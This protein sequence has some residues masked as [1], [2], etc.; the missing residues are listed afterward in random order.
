MLDGML[1]GNG[2]LLF[3]LK[4]SHLTVPILCL[5]LFLA[6][7][8]QLVVQFK[9]LNQ[10]SFCTNVL[11]PDEWMILKKSKVI[12]VPGREGP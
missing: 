1:P 2:Q 11:V 7:C 5:I 9:K 12:P 8:V 6:P 10:S 3:P 4:T